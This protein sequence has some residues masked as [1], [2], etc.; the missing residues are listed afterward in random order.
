M[1]DKPLFDFT[2][3]Y[4]KRSIAEFLLKH[5]VD[6]ETY[7][8]RSLDTPEQ[9]EYEVL[10][11]CKSKLPELEKKAK[12]Y[13]ASVIFGG[14]GN[15]SLW[16]IEKEANTAYTLVSKYLTD[17]IVFPILGTTSSELNDVVIPAYREQLY[18]IKEGVEWWKLIGEFRKPLDPLLDK[19]RETYNNYQKSIIGAHIGTKEEALELYELL[20]PTYTE[21]IETL[22]SDPN[23]MQFL[24]EFIE[25]DLENKE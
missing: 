22:K 12:L 11:L 21:Y 2:K 7:Q 16:R 4:T 8:Y 6:K 25:K 13:N 19:L 3:K 14:E 15:Y 20:K 24:K 23:F 10:Y 1:S 9:I 18:A 17:N 5:G